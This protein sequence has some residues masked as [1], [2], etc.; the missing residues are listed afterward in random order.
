[1]FSQ[2]NSFFNKISTKRSSS[3]PLLS[4]WTYWLW[5]RTPSPVHHS[6]HIVRYSAPLLISFNFL[7]NKFTLANF[8]NWVSVS[9]LFNFHTS[10][11]KCSIVSLFD[12]SCNRDCNTDSNLEWN[13]YQRI[14]ASS[15]P[16]PS[17]KI[18]S[19]SLIIINQNWS[20]NDNSLITW[21]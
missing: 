11:Y 19:I 17:L 13:N 6:M 4:L 8:S 3:I 10:S 12:I 18:K 5:K 15:D 7:I 14:I 9:L 2:G 16:P 20:I 1:M 21:P